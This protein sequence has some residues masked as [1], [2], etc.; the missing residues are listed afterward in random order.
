[1]LS[2]MA[3][4]ALRRA[5]RGWPGPVLGKTSGTPI[6]IAKCWGRTP[7]LPTGC[8]ASVPIRPT[9][10]TGAPVVRASQPTPVLPRYRRPS[11]DRVP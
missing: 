10:T 5:G 11:P 8:R 7:F 6:R 3:S 1:M 9:G 4:V 2:M